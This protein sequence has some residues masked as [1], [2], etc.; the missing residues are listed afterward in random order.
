MQ[1]RYSYLSYEFYLSSSNSY[2]VNYNTLA[3]NWSSLDGL[4][5]SSTNVRSP[6][7]TSPDDLTSSQSYRVSLTVDDGFCSTTDTLNITIED[8]LCPVADA[9]GDKRKPK[10]Q[11][12]SVILEAGASFD[13]DG[14]NL[15][16]NWISPMVKL[17]RRINNCY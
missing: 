1:A 4:E 2:D 15:T 14:T 16:Y 8:N 5:L 9:G 3:Y 13:P 17:S 7:V 12:T 6:L 10:Y 11:G